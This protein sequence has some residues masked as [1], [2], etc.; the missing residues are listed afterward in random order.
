VLFRLDPGLG[1]SSDQ[2]LNL[3]RDSPN[4]TLDAAWIDAFSERLPSVDVVTFDVFDTAV[5]RRLEA[6][7][8]VFALVESYLVRTH[9]VQFGQFAELRELA[10]ADARVLA[11]KNGYEDVTFSEIYDALPARL[12]AA[13]KL[14][15]KIKSAELHAE[16]DVV[17]PAPEIQEAVRRAIA[18]G[19]KVV[20]VSDMYLSAPDIGALLAACGYPASV[21]VLVSSET[22]CT[23]AT[24]SQWAMLRRRLSPGDR[25]LHIG[26][27]EH[28]DFNSPR[29]NGIDA[30]LFTKCR[31]DRRR[32]GPLNRDILTFSAMNRRAL[33]NSSGTEVSDFMRAFGESFGGLVVGSFVKWLEERAKQLDIEHLFFLS[34]DGYL[35]QRAWDAAGCGQ[36]SGISSSYLNVSRRVL[37]LACAA[38]PGGDGRIGRNALEIIS[39]DPHLALRCL[40]DRMGLMQCDELVADISRNLGDLDC[41]LGAR[42]EKFQKILRDHDQSILSIFKPARE[43]ALGYFRQEG[44]FGERVGIVD[45]GWHGNMQAS[46]SDL[47]KATGATTTL[48]GFYYGLWPFAQRNRHRVGWMEAAF[49]SD[50]LNLD[51]KYGFKNSVAFLEN[52]HSSPEGTTVGYANIDGRFHPATQISPHDDSQFEKIIVP[53]QDGALATISN[54]FNNSNSTGVWS[55]EFTL[56]AALAAIQRVGLSPTMEE[57][58]HLSSIH[59][60]PTFDHSKFD[61]LVPR[62]VDSDVSS[63][64]AL[65]PFWAS[66]WPVAYYLACLR[67]CS[68][69]AETLLVMDRFRPM[70][71]LVDLRTSRAIA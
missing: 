41:P 16:L 35:M 19:K 29:E 53:F 43:A 36:R 52:L 3:G 1:D 67:R 17:F 22:R 2:L 13:A 33:L 15:S 25:V 65:I 14:I 9:G 37:Y 34:R 66:E 20:F 5:S 46:I 4:R 6:P 69:P 38:E 68:S 7:V 62:L 12:P 47:R 11:D 59:H 23:K 21:D 8:D 18:A 60:S 40:L 24:G 54:I 31:S 28:S 48:Y 57:Q 39:Q 51:E 49:A 64:L 61:T 50:F 55:S 30:L 26:D 70:K 44:L 10:E 32:G 56:D 45:M 58:R 63:A 42:T 27:D 71:H